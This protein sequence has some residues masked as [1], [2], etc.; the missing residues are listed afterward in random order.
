[1]YD[2][3]QARNIIPESVSAQTLSFG[4]TRRLVAN[5]SISAHSKAK[6]TTDPSS[7]ATRRYSLPKM[8]RLPSSQRLLVCRFDVPLL[9]TSVSITAI[10]IEQIPDHGIPEYDQVT[11]LVGYVSGVSVL[12]R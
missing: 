6:L 7:S 5:C 9:I 8:H 1:M 3:K 10:L 2:S 4:Q 12:A 11:M